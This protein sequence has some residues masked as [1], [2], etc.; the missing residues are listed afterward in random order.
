MH[1]GMLY[2]LLVCTIG[3]TLLFAALVLAQVRAAVMERRLRQGQL[4]QA[5]RQEGGA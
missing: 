2:P 5:R 3:F 1:T 4:A